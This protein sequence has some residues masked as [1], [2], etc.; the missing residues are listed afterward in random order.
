MWRHFYRQYG[1]ISQEENLERCLSKMMRYKRLL[2]LHPDPDRIRREF[3][4]GEQTYGRLFA[5]L[6]EHYAERLGK[7]RWGDKSLNTERYARAIFEAYPDV[8]M[9]HMMR[10]PRDRYSSSLRRWKVIRSGIGGATALW[11]STVGLAERNLALHPAAYK[12]VRYEDLVSQPEETL[13]EICAFIG[14]DYSPEM[15]SMRGAREF[16]DKG[17]NSSYGPRKPGRISA[18][19]VGRFRDVLSDSQIAFM[20]LFATQSMRRYAYAPTRIALSGGDRLRFACFEVPFN[21]ARMLAWWGREA[22]LNVVGRKVPR[23]RIVPQRG[24]PGTAYEGKLG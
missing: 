21:F 4:Q 7:P 10:D 13:R 22:V 2:K 11:Q 3:W 1:D 24:G 6:E 15:L 14:E 23:E 18:S 16:R 12:I 5:L 19:S 9:I 17:G 20:Q 8:R